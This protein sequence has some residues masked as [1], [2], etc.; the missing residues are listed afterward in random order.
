LV[1]AN[2]WVLLLSMPSSDEHIAQQQYS[3]SAGLEAQSVFIVIPAKNEGRRIGPV[4]KKCKELG[5]EH[6]VVVDDGSSD[7]TREVALQAGAQVVQHIINL[8]AGAAT[9]TGIVWALQKGAEIIVTLDADHQHFPED[10]PRLINR[11]TNSHSEI[12]IGSR[13]LRTENHIPLSRIWFNRVGN[14]INF[15]ITGLWVT[16]SQS[17]MKAFTAEFAACVEIRMDGFEFCIELIRYA[18]HHKFHLEEIPIRVRYTP[19]TLSKGQNF[20]S[21]LRMLARLRKYF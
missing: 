14:W 17:G 10:I 5:Y 20:F 16:D 7:N 13:F 6:V 8:G 18:S 21:G 9:Q 1:R 19:D 4:I 12:V 11:L 15:L 3:L 2:N